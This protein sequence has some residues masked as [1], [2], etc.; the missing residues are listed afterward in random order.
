MLDG[1]WHV[2]GMTK[3]IFV[4]LGPFFAGCFR[5]HSLCD[6]RYI[7]NKFFVS[8]EETLLPVGLVQ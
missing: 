2:N 8:T 3:Y 6:Y 7:E 5:A 4:E 1:V